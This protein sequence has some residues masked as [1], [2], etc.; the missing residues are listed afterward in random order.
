MRV[1]CA[2]S[3]QPSLLMYLLLLLLLLPVLYGLLGASPV[4][5]GSCAHMPS[6]ASPPNL[7][8]KGGMEPAPPPDA[9]KLPFWASLSLPFALAPWLLLHPTRAACGSAAV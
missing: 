4:L 1:C 6:A 5:S 9:A 8:G 7:T 3:Q 2:L